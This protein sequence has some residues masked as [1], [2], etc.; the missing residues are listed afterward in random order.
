MAEGMLK[1]LGPEL[2]V[3]SAGTRPVGFVHPD[4]IAVMREIGIDIGGQTSKPVDRFLGQSFDCVITVCDHA[5]DECPVFTGQV[6]RRLHMGIEDPGLVSGTGDEMLAAFR[7]VRD[8][9][10]KAFFE[11]YETELK[12]NRD[13]P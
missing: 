10:R 3:F 4:A 12:A 7:D 5:R 1:T 11:L 6:G 8:R 2:A 13:T 9:M